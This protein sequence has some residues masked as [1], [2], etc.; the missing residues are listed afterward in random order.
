MLTVGLALLVLSVAAL[1]TIARWRSTQPR[2]GGRPLSVWLQQYHSASANLSPSPEAED[3]IRRIGTN[4]LPTLLRMIRARDS[5]LKQMALKWGAKQHLIKLNLIPASKLRYQAQ[6]GYEILGPA[7][8]A[9]VR[10]LIEILTNDTV[11]QVRQCTA[12]ALGFIGEDAKPAVPA[13]LVAAKDP[14]NQVR[15]SSLW[16]LSRIHAA[17]ELVVPGLIEGLADS[18]SVA[19]ENAA[20]ALGG[21]GTLATSAVP[22]LVRTMGV[23]RA[24]SS[25]LL[26][27]DP[28][29]ASR[30]ENL[31][32]TNHSPTRGWS[33]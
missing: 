22:V 21:Y 31:L 26:Q 29:A 8:K 14:D 17:P 3:A 24:A 30:A 5:V 10:E 32:S 19:R 27:I 4:A 28:E 25:A 12:S 13:L 1:I 20:I 2:Y 9:Q 23:N 33:Q 6:A 15:N 7:A 11:A 16:A 18:F